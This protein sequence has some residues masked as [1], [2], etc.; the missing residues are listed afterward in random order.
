ME[1][2]GFKFYP[3]DPYVANKIIEGEPL[4]VVFHVDNVKV[5]HKDK[6][7]VDNFQQWIDFMY[8]DPHIGR[9]KSVRVEFNGYLSMTLDYTTKGEVKIDIPK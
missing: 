9:N 1:T 7:A 8:G 6:K 5:S 4:S 3:Y 2:D